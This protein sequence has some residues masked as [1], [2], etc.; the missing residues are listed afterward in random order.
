[1]SLRQPSGLAWITRPSKRARRPDEKAQKL[2]RYGEIGAFSG[3]HLRRPV[4]GFFGELGS[5]QQPG[6]QG[7]H[8]VAAG[9]VIGGAVLSGQGLEEPGAVLAG[10]KPEQPLAR[11]GRLPGAAQPGRGRPGPV[12]QELPLVFA[13]A[14]GQPGVAESLFEPRADGVQLLEGAQPP[15]RPVPGQDP[16]VGRWQRGYGGGQDGPASFASTSRY[17]RSESSRSWVCLPD[18]EKTISRPGHSET[19]MA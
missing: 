18:L 2:S 17:S 12:E 5:A 14:A 11:L 16:A 19:R 7:R 6:Y 8:L 1:M 9:E 4:E 10:Q 3:E 13:H 15:G